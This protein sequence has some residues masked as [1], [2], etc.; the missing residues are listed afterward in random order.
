MKIFND[1]YK[2]FLDD[3]ETSRKEI[4]T[5]KDKLIKTLEEF[6]SVEDEQAL[7]NKIR[8][9]LGEPTSISKYMEDDLYYTRM[10]WKTPHGEFVKLLV[11][12][13]GFK[14]DEP[15][16]TLQEQLDNAVK[17]NDFETAI[18]LRDKIKANE[19]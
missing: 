17:R 10:T 1:L 12:P 2:Q 11:S 16:E 6:Q 19:K 13:D 18:I 8:N 7:D 5:N 14:E 15:I 3:S 4:Q 9:E